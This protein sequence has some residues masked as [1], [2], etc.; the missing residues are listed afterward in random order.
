MNYLKRIAATAICAMALVCAAQAD[1]DVAQGVK[2][3][4]LT[5]DERTAIQASATPFAAGQVI[6]NLDT[7]CLEYWNSTVWVSLCGATP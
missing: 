7:N 5:T 4:R 6:Y 3:P 1:D 2:L